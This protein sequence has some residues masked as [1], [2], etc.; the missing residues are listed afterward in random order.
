M[1]KSEIISEICHDR[2]CDIAQESMPDV[3]TFELEDTEE[4]SH[5]PSG[6]NKSVGASFSISFFKDANDSSC[7]RESCA[8]NNSTS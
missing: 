2:V 8:G 7:T 4:S 6:S 3:D 1:F 5:R